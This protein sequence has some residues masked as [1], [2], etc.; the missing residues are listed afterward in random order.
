MSQ[1]SDE[2]ELLVLLFHKWRDK[3]LVFTELRNDS[4]GIQNIMDWLQ[5]SSHYPL[6]LG[7]SNLS[8]SRNHGVCQYLGNCT[9]S[10]PGLCPQGE[11]CKYND[12]NEVKSL[13]QRTAVYQNHKNKHEFNSKGRQ[14][15]N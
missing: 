9:L 10:Y 6:S 7:F 11:D 3:A 12:C 4:V 1:H 8:E 13:P 2:E 14:A 5:G 15:S